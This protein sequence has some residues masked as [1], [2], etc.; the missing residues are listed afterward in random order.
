MYVCHDRAGC[1]VETGAGPWLFAGGWAV[2]VRNMSTSGNDDRDG[3]GMAG[4]GALRE[5]NT[6]L[7]PGK[8]RAGQYY[9][10]HE[11][12]GGLN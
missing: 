6:L 10:R 5:W 8:F 2:V 12:A 4:Y 1:V 9:A 11:G 3:S 7:S